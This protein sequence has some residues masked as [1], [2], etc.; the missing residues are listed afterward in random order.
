MRRHKKHRPQQDK[1]AT[2]PQ[3]N[4]RNYRANRQRARKRWLKPND[5]RRFHNLGVSAASKF[6]VHARASD[7]WP[8]RRWPS[9][10]SDRRRP[11]AVRSGCSDSAEVK[12][13]ER[14]DSSTDDDGSTRVGGWHD[15][16]RP[17]RACWPRASR[18]A[19]RSR[20]SIAGWETSRQAEE[21]ICTIK[22]V[23]RLYPQVEHR[24]RE[25]HHYDEPEIIAVR[26]AG[27]P[28]LLDWLRAS[29]HPE[30]QLVRHP[31]QCIR[32]EAYGTLSTG[33]STGHADTRDH[34]TP[35]LSNAEYQLR[36]ATCRAQYAVGRTTFTHRAHG[37]FAGSVRAA[38]ARIRSCNSMQLSE[39]AAWRS[40]SNRPAEQ[41]E[42][43]PRM[44][45][46]PDGAFVWVAPAR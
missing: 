5:P 38:L 27:K 18:S 16:P 19:V 33:L 39:L 31:R 17:G 3:Q 43:L 40:V 44:F 29:W 42:Q 12:T 25:L 32:T 46:E 4:R 24:I 36:R 28:Q 45:I 13:D 2:P 41:L 34:A 14:R 11:G 30:A 23:R 7:D 6:A 9:G 37:Q 8:V 21:W 1:I 35:E 15:C 22:T 20:A 26:I 10:A